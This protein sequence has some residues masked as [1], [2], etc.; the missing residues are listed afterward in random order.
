MCI[1]ESVSTFSKLDTT[2]PA[3]VSLRLAHG[4]YL[5]LHEELRG[6]RPVCE[7]MKFEVDVGVGPH[8]HRHKNT[9]T[10]ERNVI[11]CMVG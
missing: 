11:E 5:Y 7:G 6:H 4:P 8:T 9:D 10:R 2:C 1:F 3:H